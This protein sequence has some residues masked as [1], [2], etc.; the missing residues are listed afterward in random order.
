[1]ENTNRR[2]QHS[3][4]VSYAVEVRSSFDPNLHDAEVWER[5]L[6]AGKMRF[7]F[8]PTEN[9]FD[10]LF[11]APIRTPPRTGLS[12][13]GR[14]PATRLEQEGMTPFDLDDA[15][16]EEYAEEY[17]RMAAMADFEDLT[18]EEI[19]SWSDMEDLA[20]LGNEENDMDVS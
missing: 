3:Y 4:R 15:E 9:I 13:P 19:F 17:A 12:T 7:R 11:E 2:Q 5:E 8:P 16:L 6:L 18:E 10:I 20:Q 1:M 14:V